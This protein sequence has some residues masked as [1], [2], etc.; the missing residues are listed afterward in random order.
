MLQSMT[1]SIWPTEI[2]TEA[3][4]TGVIDIRTFLQGQV[5]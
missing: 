4:L 3:T 1:S 5:F 2:A